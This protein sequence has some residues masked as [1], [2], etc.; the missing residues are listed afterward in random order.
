MSGKVERP[1][2]PRLAAIVESSHDAIIG[3]GLDG[4]VFAWNSAAVR[5]FGY[6]AAEIIGQPI[7]II[8]PPDRVEEEQ[9]ILN[10]IGRGERVDYYKTVRCHKDGHIISVSVTISPIRDISG[11]IVGASTIV[12]DLTDRNIRNQRIQELK[13]E[14]VHLQRLTE[15]GQLV[16]T[17]VH[18]VNQPLTAISNYVNACRRLITTGNHDR[19]SIA[20]D[21]IADQTQR[22]RDFVQKRDV[23]M[24][25]EDLSQV[26]HEAIELTRTSVSDTG[27]ILTV[28]LDSTQFAVKIDK[29]QVQQVLF[30]LLR[31]GIEAMQ[32]QPRRVLIVSANSA[33]GE[34]VEI[35]VADTGPG[36]A[37][38]VRAKLFQPFVTTKANGMGVGLSVCRA[39]V[40]SQSGRLWAED[41]PGGGTVFRFTVS[42]AVG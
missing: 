2:D 9:V 27:L 29:V 30:N 10:R 5:L 12:L 15:L 37:A 35:S 26:I 8:F 36:L 17:L 4:V 6:T 11:M 18:E 32:G 31:N 23:Q 22:I 40:E 42:R 7:T 33:L 20:L 3:K 19:V 38:E 16:S 21:R 13:A 34:M 1:E 14:L 25:V 28:Q 39:I 24:R 41:N